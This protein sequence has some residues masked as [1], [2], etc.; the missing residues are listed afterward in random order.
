MMSG[1]PNLDIQ[2]FKKDLAT[3]PEN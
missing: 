3:V 2:P 1:T